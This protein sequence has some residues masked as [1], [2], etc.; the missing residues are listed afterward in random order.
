MRTIVLCVLFSACAQEAEE[1]GEVVQL[2]CNCSIDP[3]PCCCTT[4]ILLD[5]AGDGISLTAPEEGVSFELADGQIGPWSWTHAGSDDAWLV[6]DRTMNGVIDDG[7]EMF[8]SSAPQ[9]HPAPGK[10]RNGYAALADLDRDGDGWVNASEAMFDAL[11]LWQDSDHDGRSDPAE[12]LRLSDL[13]IES[14]SV[15]YRDVR[16]P[17]GR[18]NVIRYTAP[19]QTAPG[20]NVAMQSYDVVLASASKAERQLMGLPDE[21]HGQ[22]SLVAKSDLPGPGRSAAVRRDGHK[23]DNCV[24]DPVVRRPIRGGSLPDYPELVVGKGG[25]TQAGGSCPTTRGVTVALFQKHTSGS[26]YVRSSQNW[27]SVA[28]WSENP[29]PGLPRRQALAS[30]NCQNDATRDWFTQIAVAGSVVSST[31]FTTDCNSIVASPP[32]PGCGGQ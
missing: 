16:R 31:A 2:Q 21:L 13:G 25:Y 28:T 7:I 15:K 32:G 17:D 5:L 9:P 27:P 20:S 8:S 10:Q 11:R 4:P 1:T 14:L 12:L 23:I 26:W 30:Q 22:P 29:G 6:L 19:V 18:G 3:Q 24:V